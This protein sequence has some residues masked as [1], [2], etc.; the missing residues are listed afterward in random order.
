[1]SS[2]DFENLLHARL[3]ELRQQV[4]DLRSA[5]SDLWFSRRGTDHSQFQ[6]LRVAEEALDK[7][8][9]SLTAHP[10]E[11]ATAGR[12]LAGARTNVEEVQEFVSRYVRSAAAFLGLNA[13]VGLGAALWGTVY[14]WS[15]TG[16]EPPLPSWLFP[17]PADPHRWLSLRA[18]LLAACGGLAGSALNLGRTLYLAA[19]GRSLDRRSLLSFHLSPIFGCGLA[20]AGAVIMRAFGG[21]LGASPPADANGAVPNSATMFAIG[22][23]VGFVPSAV[24]ER[25]AGLVKTLFGTDDV[26]NPVVGPPSVTVAHG[27]VEASVTVTANTAARVAGVNALLTGPNG[28]IGFPLA[29][30]SGGKWSGSLPVPPQFAGATGVMLSVEAADQQGKVGRSA[31]VP[32]P[33]ADSLL[34]PSDTI[35]G[36]GSAPASP[37]ASVHPEPPAPA[38]P[39]AGSPI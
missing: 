39:N 24:H 22:L 19:P 1:V 13:V 21:L 14:F 31:P 6:T 35:H 9:E 30:G 17:V 33:L 25:L 7:A 26:S 8:Q 11:P 4:T 28:V 3:R 15:A 20:A 16:S 27:Q 37:P 2:S 5:L 23:V 12:H 34:E 10:A 29:P 18:V 36:D 32:V 38:D